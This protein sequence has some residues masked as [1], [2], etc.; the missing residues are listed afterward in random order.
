MPNT[1]AET[2][3]L[4]AVDE[5]PADDDTTSAPAAA[6]DAAAADAEEAAAEEERPAQAESRCAM[7]LAALKA[8]P[9][10]AFDQLVERWKAWKQRK[11][12]QM[13]MCGMSFC[14]YY[15]WGESQ[16]QRQAWVSAQARLQQQRY[17]EGSALNKWRVGMIV[18]VE[19]EDGVE[20]GVP[21]P[22]NIHRIF[23]CSICMQISMCILH[24]YC[25]EQVEILG[26]AASGAPTELRVRFADGT[27]DDWGVDDFLERKIEA[28]PGQVAPAT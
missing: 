8:A 9:R 16:E 15:C 24:I 27:D 22:D 17:A 19:T 23:I 18:D 12:D 10:K 25:P 21:S 26:P 5:P 13:T 3:P 11:K 1:V 28:I 2:P 20:T 14:H 7:R 4:A 6:S